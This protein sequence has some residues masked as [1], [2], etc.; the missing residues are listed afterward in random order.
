MVGC[1][2]DGVDS[3]AD[4]ISYAVH[5][6]DDSLKAL[7]LARRNDGWTN[8]LDSTV[9]SQ[10]TENSVSKLEEHFI[11]ISSLHCDLLC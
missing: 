7:D 1:L 2:A 5:M 4:G 10:A 9:L 8:I 6:G 11:S 3:S